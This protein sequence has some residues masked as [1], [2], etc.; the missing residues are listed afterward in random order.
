MITEFILSSCYATQWNYIYKPKNT[1]LNGAEIKPTYLNS[2]RYTA[3]K[4]AI[5]NS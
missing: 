3:I 2:I 4:S 1:V 5:Y